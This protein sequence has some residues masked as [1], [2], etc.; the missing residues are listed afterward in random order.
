MVQL[1]GQNNFIILLAEDGS[2]MY[3]L[4][5]VWQR[6]LHGIRTF[7]DK[8][9]I[10]IGDFDIHQFVSFFMIVAQYGNQDDLHV[11]QILYHSNAVFFIG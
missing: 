5:R 2:D 11:R 6:D 7:Y 4:V 8:A 9:R 1:I 10:D 3:G